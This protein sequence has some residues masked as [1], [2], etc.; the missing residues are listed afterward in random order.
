M[1]YI[2]WN[3]VVSVRVKEIDDQHKVLI[4]MINS[5]HTALLLNEA[6]KSQ[7]IVVDKMVD[8]ASRHFPLEEKYMTQY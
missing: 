2:K 3:D 8:S 1:A 7:K 5:L 4:E 6:R